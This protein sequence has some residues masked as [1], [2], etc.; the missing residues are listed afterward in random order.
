M[1]IQSV[2]VRVSLL[3]CG[4]VCELISHSE[5]KLADHSKSKHKETSESFSQT[6][7]INLNTKPFV[8][9]ECFYCGILIQSESHLSE[10]FEKC[11]IIGEQNQI[12]MKKESDENKAT[13]MYHALSKVFQLQ[14]TKRF[15]CV[16]CPE[17]FEFD[18]ML[19]LHM[20]LGH[21][22]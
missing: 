15:P 17:T 1:I 9:Y 10:H 20:M 5:S 16:I 13:K 14:V 21:P 18:S 12:K 19:E 3:S 11:E 22:S 4:E 6:M 7:E 2:R 8:Q